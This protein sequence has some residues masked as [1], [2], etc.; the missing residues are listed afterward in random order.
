MSEEETTFLYELARN[1]E[2]LKLL[3]YLT[4]AEKPII[5]Y[6]AAELLGGLTTSRN[7]E[8]RERATRALRRTAKTDDHEAVRAAA[9]DALYLRDED[10]LEALVEEV[11]A[12]GADDPPAWTRVDHITEWLEADYPEF[13]LIAADALGRIGDESAVPALVGVLDDPDVRV[14]VR[15]VEACGEIGDPR[16]IDALADHLEDSHDQVRREAATALAKIGTEAA[17]AAL[18]PAARSRTESVRVIAIDALGSAGSLEALPLLIDGLE[19]NGELVRR[20][21]TRSILELLANAPPD[22]SHTIRNE[23]ADAVVDASPPDLESQLL[24]ILSGNQPAHLRRNAIWLL[25]QIVDA[26]SDRLE[27]VHEHLIAALD[28]PD[29]I[30]AKFATSAL[31]ELEN[32]GLAARLRRTIEDGDLGETAQSRA[33][34]VLEKIRRKRG[35]SKEAVTNSVEF[36]YVDDPSDYT[37]KKRNEENGSDSA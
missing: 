22:R 9:I 17:M 28:D 24:T 1:A 26:D 18:A 4:D 14:R 33:E 10:A 23:V 15:A 12:A 27:A 32:T 20:T 6:R 37:A 29:E 8:A 16:A 25:G 21:A 7:Q 34:F 3:E 35:P 13:R 11:A 36:T 19:D 5:R 31:V 30:T 2:E